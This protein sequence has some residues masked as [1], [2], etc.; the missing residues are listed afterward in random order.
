MSGK[1]LSLK[2]LRAL[3]D[4]DQKAIR[5]CKKDKLAAL[6]INDRIDVKDIENAIVSFSNRHKDITCLCFA[7]GYSNA[8]TVQQL[9]QAGADVNTTD[10]RGNTPLYWVFSSKIEVKQKIYYLL[11]CDASLRRARNMLNNTP[12]LVAAC[13][14]FDDAI[15]VLI[16]HGAEVNERGFLGRTALFSL[17]AMD[18]SHASMS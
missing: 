5:E 12:L 2:L 18:T 8:R 10:S 6:W 11:S 17:V 13:E 4:R 16:Q 7:S 3:N 14:G 1:D 9:V 15:T